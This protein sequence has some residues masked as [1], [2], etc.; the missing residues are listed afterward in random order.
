MTSPNN[1]TPSNS[2]VAGPFETL[3]ACKIVY[4]ALRSG[5]G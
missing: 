2:P 3:D 1:L 4:L 5:H